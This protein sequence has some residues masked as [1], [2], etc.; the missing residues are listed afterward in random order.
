MGAILPDR[1]IDSPLLTDPPEPAAPEGFLLPAARPHRTTRPRP[2]RETRISGL[3][4]G[5]RVSKRAG[6]AGGN[7]AISRT[8]M[9]ERTL[10]VRNT[11]RVD[12][13]AIEF[14]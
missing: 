4:L 2:E 9:A 3:A 5:R 1:K 6:P 11:R 7:E 8:P 10:M 12:S 14:F 13:A